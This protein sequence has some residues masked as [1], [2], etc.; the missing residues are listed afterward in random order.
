[1]GFQVTEWTFLTRTSRFTPALKDNKPP[2]WCLL[3]L[4]GMCWTSGG[5]GEGWAHL[6]RAAAALQSKST[7]LWYLLWEEIL[8]TFANVRLLKI[9]RGSRV[10]APQLTNQTPQEE[11]NV[12]DWHRL[13]ARSLHHS[14][15]TVKAKIHNDEEVRSCWLNKKLK[16]DNPWIRW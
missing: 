12:S 16:Y 7:T 13:A 9:N 14:V 5:G 8:P 4:S 1:M 15:L 2:N 11:M 6:Q 10:V 3:K